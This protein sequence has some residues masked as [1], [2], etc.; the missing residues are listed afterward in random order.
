MVF[1][2]FLIDVGSID[3]FALCFLL[4]FIYSALGDLLPGCQ[5]WLISMK[6]VFFDVSA[7]TGHLKTC[8]NHLW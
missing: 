2:A 6:R 5:S 3:V 4:F 7:K 8:F 1:L